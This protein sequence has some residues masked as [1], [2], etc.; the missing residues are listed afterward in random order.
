[1]L[2]GTVAT[3]AVPI[4]P[5]VFKP[6]LLTD[7]AWTNVSDGQN[8]I[9]NKQPGNVIVFTSGTGSRSTL[10]QGD[11][12]FAGG[13]VQVV[14]TLMVPPVRIEPT[15]RVNYPDLTAFLGALYAADLVDEFANT[16]NATIFAPNN[17]AFQLV[18]DSLSKL[19]KADLQAVMRYHLAPTAGVLP[20]TSLLNG[21][22]ITTY[23]DKKTP[24]VVRQAGN[25]LYIDRAQLLQPNI[26]VANGVVHI[27]DNVLN[28]SVPSATPDPVIGTQAPVFAG[29]GATGT[30]QPTPFTTALP[31]TAN[32]P[33]TTSAAA[34]GTATDAASGSGKATGTGTVRT[35]SSAGLAAGVAMP[36]CT[37]MAAMGVGAGLAGVVGMGL[38][39]IV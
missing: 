1:M 18:A 39:G 22:V 8:M 4:G 25:N 13:L 17:G 5:S 26:L 32:C 9:I 6:T 37:G 10:V 30:D 35:V 27:I 20:A 31:C 29:T 23:T 21:T 34:N 15:C 28:P 24:L 7:H 19:S 14:D 2:Q 38:A 12:A 36:R 3:N 16:P 33:V 11:I